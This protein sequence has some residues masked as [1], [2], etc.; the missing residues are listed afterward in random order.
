MFNHF[1]YADDIVLL[2]PSVAGLQELLDICKDHA[3]VHDIIFNSTKSMC[4]C[5]LVRKLSHYSIW[6]AVGMSLHFLTLVM[7]SLA[8]QLMMLILLVST[9]LYACVP[10]L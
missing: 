5:P 7:F 6:R 9:G 10:T 2:S 8:M 4:F 3:S 1:S